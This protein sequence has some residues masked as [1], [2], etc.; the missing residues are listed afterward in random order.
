MSLKTVLKWTLRLAA[1][2]AT[3][4]G[5][6]ETIRNRFFLVDIITEKA[7]KLRRRFK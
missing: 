2:A 4:F 3:V 6:L 7:S 5:V 1:I